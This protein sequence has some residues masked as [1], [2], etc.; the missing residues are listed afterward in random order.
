MA[1]WGVRVVGK[2]GAAT[3]KNKMENTFKDGEATGRKEHGSLVAGNPCHRSWSSLLYEKETNFY[4][5]KGK[6]F[7]ALILFK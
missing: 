1:G 5:M 7:V 2:P 6:K 3:L 4:L